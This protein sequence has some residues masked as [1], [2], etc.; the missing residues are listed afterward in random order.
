MAAQPPASND[1]PEANPPPTPAEVVTQFSQA[2]RSGAAPAIDPFLAAASCPAPETRRSLLLELIKID[3]A[4]RWYFSCAVRDESA[5]GA[6]GG[7]GTGGGSSVDVLLIEDYLSQWS[8]VLGTIDDVPTELIVHEFQLRRRFG[9]RP[10]VDDY[11]LRFHTQADRVRK[12]LA[13]FAGGTPMDRERDAP[14]GPVAKPPWSMVARETLQADPLNKESARGTDDVT[15]VAP[16]QSLDEVP[17][18]DSRTPCRFGNYELLEEV[19]HGAMGVVFRARQRHPDRTVALKLM[20]AGELATSEEIRRFHADAQLAASLQHPNVVHIIE[21][22]EVNGRHFISMEFIDGPTLADLVRERPMDSATAARYMKVIAETV[23]FAHTRRP[24][25]IHRDLKPANV[26]IDPNGQPRIT[27]F[28]IAKR[29]DETDAGQTRQGSVMGTPSYMPPEQAM[30]LTDRIGP[31]SDVYGLGAILYHLLTGRPPFSAPT[32]MDTL[33][34]VTQSEPVAPRLLNPDVDPD[35]EAVCLKC[36]EK[37]PRDRLAS[38]QAVAEEMERVLRGEPTLTRPVST[39]TRFRKWC[40]RNPT[41]A[42]LSSLLAILL[43]AAS[44]AST[45]AW[46]HQKRLYEEL[47]ERSGQLQT[48]K[49][50]LAEAAH[51]RDEINREKQQALD[52]VEEAKKLLKAL[53]RDRKRLE[54]ENE[55]LAHA[56]QRLEAEKTQLDKKLTEAKK[57]LQAAVAQRRQA[58][59]EADRAEAEAERNRDLA[60]QT[61]KKALIYLAQEALKDVPGMDPIRRD[62]A[63]EARQLFGQLQTRHADRTVL[64]DLGEARRLLGSIYHLLGE[65]QDAESE[66]SKAIELFESLVKRFPDEPSYRLQLL[67]CYRDRGDLWT[68]RARADEARRDYRRALEVGEW[69]AAHATRRQDATDWKFQVA[70]THNNFYKLLFQTGDLD[71]AENQL[72]LC[73]HIYEEL[74]RQELAKQEDR[75]KVRQKLATAYNNLGTLYLWRNGSEKATAEQH[76]Q[77]ASE[78]VRWLQKAISIQRELLQQNPRS[79]E[80]REDYARSHQNLAEALFELALASGNGQDE[81]RDSSH[82]QRLQRATE[83]VGTALNEFQNLKD[84]FPDTRSYCEQL[85]QARLVATQVRWAMRQYDEAIAICSKAVGSLQGVAEAQPNPSCLRSL[86]AAHILRA[87]VLADRFAT[88]RRPE[89]KESACNDLTRAERVLARLPQQ[90]P[91]Q[92]GSGNTEELVKR[93]QEAR[94]YLDCR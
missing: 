79:R 30:G 21:S 52:E 35:L 93:I 89:D 15:R 41:V 46:R 71:E 19:A 42:S 36:L 78:A 74:A 26:L 76:R 25:I 13:P 61:L 23:H 51:V 7:A 69:L 82:D 33:I 62:V 12:A 24:P 10:S 31:H 27:D 17:S 77:A 38:A 29:I 64:E 39:W 1:R 32:V 6:G 87:Q 4:N 44:I 68:D 50:E 92:T 70:R 11:L 59:A 53:Q 8:D 45:L 2:W 65:Y 94:R 37:D 83:A 18:G 22:G 75:R 60:R 28:G 63:K 20:R 55:Q 84:D 66:L 88:S 49:E 9:N 16:P 90:A 34:Q 80:Y 85:N 5:S 3:M 40:R 56:T 57:H 81:R 47:E 54:Q 58:Q 67:K 91:N 86:A 43:V 72:T 73:R 14:A 48:V